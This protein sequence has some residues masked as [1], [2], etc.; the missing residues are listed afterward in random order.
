MLLLL[1]SKLA[2]FPFAG[3]IIKNFSNYCLCIYFICL[4]FGYLVSAYLG[5]FYAFIKHNYMLKNWCFLHVYSIISKHMLLKMFHSHWRSN[6]LHH[7][8]SPQILRQPKQVIFLVSYCP[9]ASLSKIYCMNIRKY[10]EI[11]I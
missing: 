9:T 8:S 3:I 11:M 10:S 5:R 4:F 1:N 7:L 2:L 6:L